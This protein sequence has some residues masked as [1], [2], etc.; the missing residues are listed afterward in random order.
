M[1]VDPRKKEI[2]IDAMIMLCLFY[3]IAHPST[4]KITSKYSTSLMKKDPVF[5][6]SVVFFLCYILIQKITKKF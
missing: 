4:Y 2:L 6:H 5:L 3:I 1:F